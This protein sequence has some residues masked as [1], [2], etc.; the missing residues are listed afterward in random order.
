MSLIVDASVAIRWYLPE[1]GWREAEAILHEPEE[2]IAPDLII[3]EIGS[4]IWKRIRRG[5][6]PRGFE[7]GLLERAAS[8]FDVLVPSSELGSDALKLALSV[9][10]PIYDCFY[11][12]LCRRENA[13]LVT[14]DRRLA[15]IA[16]EIG[17]LTRP[18]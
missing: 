5:D 6:I 1:D 11:L 2:L 15:A 9:G 4:A 13:G 8:A 17:I 14:A 12:S 3:A 7:T 16:S 18:L 10:H